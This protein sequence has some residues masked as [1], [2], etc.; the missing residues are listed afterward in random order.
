[1]SKFVRKIGFAEV[2]YSELRRNIM[3]VEHSER[4]V[5]IAETIGDGIP[6]VVLQRV[7]VVFRNGEGGGHHDQHGEILTTEQIHMS[8]ESLQN[9]S[10]GVFAKMVRL[11][12]EDDRRLPGPIH[13]SPRT[14]KREGSASCLL[15]DLEGAIEKIVIPALLEELQNGIVDIVGKSDAKLGSRH[16]SQVLQM[17]KATPMR[18]SWE[19]SNHRGTGQ[20]GDLYVSQVMRKKDLMIKQSEVSLLNWFVSEPLYDWKSVD[21]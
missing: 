10:Q 12:N 8:D 20:L 5:F 16:V 14:I 6:S 11:I 4:E 9:V 15:T 21:G 3:Q 13:L 18:L 17:T 1:M 2:N 19:Y 7:P